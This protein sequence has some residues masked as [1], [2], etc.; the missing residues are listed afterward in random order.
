MSRSPNRRRPTPLREV[1]A[2][3][4]AWPS[5]ALMA[6][7][8]AWLLAGWLVKAVESPDT[9]RLVFSWGCAGAGAAL[10]IAPSP[11]QKRLTAF[12]W[13]ILRPPLVWIRD[14]LDRHRT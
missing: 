9:A 8:F 13:R 10:A 5:I 14:V 7:G 1:A 2:A 12:V 6:G 11:E 3:L 4:V